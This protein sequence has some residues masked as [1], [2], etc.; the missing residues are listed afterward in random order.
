MREERRFIDMGQQ[1]GNEFSSVEALWS[2]F[3][4]V[5]GREPEDVKGEGD[6]SRS[7][8]G[9]QSRAEGEGKEDGEENGRRSK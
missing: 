2:Q 4:N 3:E 9:R 6:Q 5:M 7:Q 8:S 1:I